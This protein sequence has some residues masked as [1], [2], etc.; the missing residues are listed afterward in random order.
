MATKDSI[1]GMLHEKGKHIGKL[2]AF[3][4]LTEF[5]ML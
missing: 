2:M 1:S 4:R 5:V 3:T